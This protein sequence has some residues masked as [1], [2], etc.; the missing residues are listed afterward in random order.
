MK[1]DPPT[2]SA[3]SRSDTRSVSDTRSDTRPAS[4][5]PKLRSNDVFGGAAAT[6][7]KVPSIDLAHPPLALKRDPARLAWVK[8]LAENPFLDVD[9]DKTRFTATEWNI[10]LAYLPTFGGQA[11]DLPALQPLFGGKPPR[12]AHLTI[13]EAAM[14]L[15]GRPGVTDALLALVKSTRFNP[16]PASGAL[17]ASALHEAAAHPELFTYSERQGVATL[18]AAVDFATMKSLTQEAFNAAFA[19]RTLGLAELSADPDVNSAL[20]AAGLSFDRL[21]TGDVDHDGLVFADE[22]SALFSSLAGPAGTLAMRDGQGRRTALGALASAL[23]RASLKPVALPGLPDDLKRTRDA[24]IAKGQAVFNQPYP[25]DVP[26]PGSVNALKLQLPVARGASVICVQGNNSMF[27]PATHAPTALRYALDFYAPDRGPRQPV[28]AMAAGTAYVYGNAR[29]DQPDNFGLGNIVLVDHHNGYA[30]LYAHLAD[31]NVTTGQTVSA[32]D[33]VGGIGQTGMAGANHLHLQVVRLLRQ[34][35]PAHEAYQA[36]PGEL[37]SAT[38]PWGE[39]VPFTVT[40]R[41]VTLGET[42]VRRIGSR[43]FRSS[44]DDL[45]GSPHEYSR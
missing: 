19:G 39:S 18:A 20:H 14:M 37:P 27:D 29:I 12:A 4:G 45:L 24:L 2:L 44:E 16:T 34:P 1:I 11:S 25:V 9:K 42:T 35:D 40:A 5:T 6:A 15:G 31:A 3:L 13:A 41:D 22:F 10:A 32:G 28:A 38:P 21:R 17:T 23:E 8:A 30:T 7:T 36:K 26:E 33:I 43:D